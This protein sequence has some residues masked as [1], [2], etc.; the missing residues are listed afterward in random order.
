MK[1]HALGPGGWVQV[2]KNQW[3]RTIASLKP[4]DVTIYSSGVAIG[5]EPGMDGGWGDDVPRKGHQSVSVPDECSTSLGH[6]V[7]WHGPC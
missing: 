3:P 4:Y 6:G 1:T 7:F 5:I 2:P